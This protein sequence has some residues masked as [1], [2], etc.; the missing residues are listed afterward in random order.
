M[1]TARPRGGIHAIELTILDAMREAHEMNVEL[2][3]SHSERRE[4]EERAKRRRR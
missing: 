3:K 1:S 4:Q 2:M